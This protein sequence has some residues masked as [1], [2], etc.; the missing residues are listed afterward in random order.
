MCLSLAHFM[1]LP[2]SQTKRIDPALPSFS[3]F[4]WG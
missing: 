4:M 3:A 2:P 1:L